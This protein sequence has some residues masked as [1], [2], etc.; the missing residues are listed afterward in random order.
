MSRIGRQPIPVPPN[1]QVRVEPTRLLVQGPRGQVEVPYGHGIQFRLEDGRLVALRK[2][3][4]KTQK[5]LHG[6]YRTLA[7]NAVRGV[8]EGF[9]V[10]M[11]VVGTGYRVEKKGNALVFYVGYSHPV[12]VPIPPG[13]DVEFDPKNKNRFTLRG[14]DKYVL[15]Q[16]AATI[17]SIRPPM[18]YK[19][20]GI[21]YVDEP[22]RLKPGKS[23]AKK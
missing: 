23:A 18:T 12:E 10:G 20:K 21:K 22:W 15:G 7:A 4:S 14:P 13:V 9:S 8:T 11:E 3:D 5:A 6:L 17:R 1:V 2:D 19:A 16:Y